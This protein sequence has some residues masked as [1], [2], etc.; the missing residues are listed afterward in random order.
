MATSLRRACSSQAAAIAALLASSHL[1]AAEPSPQS[2][3]LNALIQQAEAAM[4]NLEL[5]EARNLWARIHHLDP[6]PMA[7]CQLGVVNTRLG[8]WDVAATELSEC[9]ARMPPPKNPIERRRWEVRH[10][11]FARVLQEVGEV[12]IFTAPGVAAA[13]IF[14]D[15]REVTRAD[16]VYVLPGRHE[17]VAMAYDGRIARVSV[18]A[19]AGESQG[20]PIAFERFESRPAL[21]AGTVA[22]PLAPTRAA[23]S[24][25]APSGVKPW[26][27]AGGAT[28]AVGLLVTG[29]GLHIAA[30]SQ[31]DARQAA[32]CKP[33]REGKDAHTD[34]SV[35]GVSTMSHLGTASLTA[36]ALLGVATFAYVVIAADTELRARPGGAEVKVQ[37]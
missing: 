26:V 21:P 37:W 10:A 35:E 22:G 6:S 8:R 2:K 9:V 12:H 32:L 33:E 23:L 36:G 17:I 13:H 5:G 28:A 18:T 4:K 29:I 30:N 7:I 20:V 31:E 19:K 11:D 16:R 24:E 14:V 34:V 1:N 27:V 25:P 15:G 3:E